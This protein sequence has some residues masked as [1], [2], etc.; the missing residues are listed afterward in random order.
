MFGI[1]AVVTFGLDFVLIGLRAVTN[2]W[3][4]PVGLV[5][6]GSAFLALHLLGA[7]DRMRSM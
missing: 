3:F 4:S 2:S 6:L 7:W 1:L 5:A